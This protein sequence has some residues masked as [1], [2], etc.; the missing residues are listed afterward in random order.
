M[1]ANNDPIANKLGIVPMKSEDYINNL[2]SESHDDSAKK[3]FETARSNV[4]S[5]IEH[6]NEAIFELAQVAKQSQNPRAFEVLGQLINAG[7]SSSKQLLDL[8][9]KIREITN[10]E[11]IMKENSGVTNVNN[12]IFVG[13]TSDLQNLIKQQ[14]NIDEN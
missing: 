13:S 9:L 2:I 7:L 3:D 11:T 8:Q 4:N 1:T 10:V 14:K 12:A 5:L 6:T